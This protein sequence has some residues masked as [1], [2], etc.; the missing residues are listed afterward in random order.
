MEGEHWDRW[1]GVMREEVPKRQIQAGDE[2]GSW[3]PEGDRW[4][5]HGGRL[6]T[7]CLLTYMLEVYY[8]HLPLYSQELP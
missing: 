4:A 3:S 5:I 7:T 1:N 2:V 6:Y 8:R